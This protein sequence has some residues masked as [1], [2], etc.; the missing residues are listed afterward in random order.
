MLLG[1]ISRLRQ[2][3]SLTGLRWALIFVLFASTLP[4]QDARALDSGW[5]TLN[6]HR[7]DGTLQ[8][9]RT[10]P[11]DNIE[12]LFPKGD[13]V[14]DRE[15]LPTD[16]RAP[17]AL[18]SKKIQFVLVSDTQKRFSIR[19]IT[20]GDQLFLF[21]EFFCRQNPDVMSKL[22]RATSFYPRNT[23][24]ALNL[25][26]VYLVLADYGFEDPRRLVISSAS[27]VPSLPE[28]VPWIDINDVKSVIRPP[29]IRR[30][31][32][33]FYVDLFTC[34]LHMPWVR[35]NRMNIGPED[36]QNV[37]TQDIFPD[38]MD[39]QVLDEQVRKNATSGIKEKVVFESGGIADGDTSD[40][41]DF[42]TWHFDASDGPGVEQIRSNYKT[43][44]HA[45]GE[46]ERILKRAISVTESGPWIDEHGKTVG[47][48]TLVIFFDDKHELWAA[49]VFESETTVLEIICACHD[50]LLAAG[51]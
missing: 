42:S 50:N 27:Q 12:L 13:A 46:W 22:M 32:A 49:R 18:R 34:D 1:Y 6:I 10:F 5:A 17:K 23:K 11:K 3:R 43:H 44:A 30:E 48:K 41:C 39:A 21:D 45:D 25:A 37:R 38:Y 51:E 4:A 36:L 33:G 31:G 35:H 7:E 19:G 15:P 28:P 40:G 20:Y 8:Q 9:F 29:V 14:L 47:K 24:E 16:W 2:A 26:K